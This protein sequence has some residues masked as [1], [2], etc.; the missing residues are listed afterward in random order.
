MLYICLVDAWG[1]RFGRTSWQNWSWWITVCRRL[2]V[3]R[4]GFSLLF[5]FCTAS[6]IT[7]F[8]RTLRLHRFVLFTVCLF[9]SR[10]IQ[11]AQDNKTL[12]EMT[13]SH[14]R[15]EECTNIWKFLFHLK[16]VFR[17]FILRLFFFKLPFKCFRPDIFFN[18]S[19]FLFPHDALNCL[20]VTVNIFIMLQKIRF[21]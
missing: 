5:I 21:K 3:R 6:V 10:R 11:Q 7:L 17:P 15:C 13:D 19:V 14:V 16:T 12:I 2:R 20:K 1:K 8:S 9:P 4:S 18:K